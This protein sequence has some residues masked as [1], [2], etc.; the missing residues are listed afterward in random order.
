MTPRYGSRLASV[1]LLLVSAAL[2]LGAA[3]LTL[4]WL[5]RPEV[6]GPLGWKTSLEW[7]E[8]TNELG[9]RAKRPARRKPGE[10]IL[11][12]GDSQIEG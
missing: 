6:R 12:L 1:V 7:S 3:E 11:L 10:R 8:G 2:A 5:A 4:R 9:F